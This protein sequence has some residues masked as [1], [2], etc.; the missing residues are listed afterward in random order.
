MN[1]GQRPSGAEIVAPGEVVTEQAASA[2]PGAS[3]HQAERDRRLRWAIMSSLLVRP[4][5]VLIPLIV[6]PVF[7]RYLGK[8]RYGLYEAISS[9]AVWVS[10]SNMGLGFGLLNRL[11]DCYVTGDRVLARRYV[12]S[13][14]FASVG[15]TVLGSVLV[16]AVVLSVDWR[17]LLNVEAG[18]ANAEL[19]WSVWLAC[20][21]PLIGITFSIAPAAYSAY[22]EL[23]RQNAWDGIAKIAAFGACLAVPFTP[24]GISGAILALS[25]VP[26]AVAI[27]SHLYLWFIAKPWLRPTIGFFDVSILWKLLST[28][29]LLFVLQSSVA[30]MFQADRIV[31]GLLRTPGEVADY[32]V[33][34]RIF[35]LAYG[36]VYLVL[37]ALWPAYGEAFR[38]GDVEWCRRKLRQSLIIG[39]AGIF[40]C[41]GVMM[42]A[43]DQVLALLMGSR[44]IAVPLAVTAGLTLGFAL[45]VWADGHAVLLVG[46]DVLRPQVLAVGSNAVL[47]LAINVVATSRF[48]IVGT[49]WSYPIAALLSTTWAYPYILRRFLKHRASLAPA[50]ADERWSGIPINPQAPS[51]SVPLSPGA[52]P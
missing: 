13:L 17:A 48:G 52:M 24:L 2:R 27:G 42:I 47:A 20:V 15:I 38:R 1:S 12:S 30:L 9:L 51:A 41:G 32:G 35:M 46:A 7:L 3:E 11:T 33:M 19:R 16:T 43:G 28:G 8:Q 40:V 6:V 14:F 31:I 18:V 4:L 26:V 22:Q 36:V 50:D 39:M 10:L 21:I 25:A 49:A 29:F 23:H 44:A 45:R 37:T 5:A 34:I